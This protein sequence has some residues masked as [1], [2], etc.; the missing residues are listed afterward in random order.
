MFGSGTACAISPISSVE[1]LGQL[2]EIPTMDHVNPMHRKIRDHLY[3]IQYGHI[4]H[5]WAP[6]IE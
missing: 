3:A 2:L 4:E 1:Y 5:P 6:I